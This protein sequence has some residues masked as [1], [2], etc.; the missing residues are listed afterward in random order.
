MIGNDNKN[1][2]NYNTTVVNNLLIG[3]LIEYKE[4]QIDGN[5]IFLLFF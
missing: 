4:Q 3:I 5:S 2:Y 1:N